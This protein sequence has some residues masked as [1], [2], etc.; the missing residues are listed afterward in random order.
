MSTIYVLG[1]DLGMTS[2]KAAF[3]RQDGSIACQAS[4]RVEPEF[5]QNSWVEINPE[6]WWS[7][8]CSLSKSLLETGGI[9]KSEVKGIAIASAASG[10]TAIDKNRKPLRKSIIWLDNR[11][12][13]DAD[14]LM[15]TFG[16]KDLFFEQTGM[17]LSGRD[18]IVKHIWL[19]QNEPELYA[20][21]RYFLDDA[22]YIL[23]RA[24]GTCVCSRPNAS[25]IAL[26]LE[27]GE[28]DRNLLNAFELDHK[29]YP[30]LVNS[31]ELVGWLTGRAAKD[32]G[33]LAGTSVFGGCTDINGIELGSGCCKP[34]DAFFYLGTSGHVG[35]MSAEVQKPSLAAMPIASTVPDNV[36]MLGTSEV[37]GGCLMWAVENLYKHEFETLGMEALNFADEQLLKTKPGADGLIFANWLCGEGERN[38]MLDECA[39]GGFINLSINHTRDHMLRAIF[40]GCTLQMVWIV[41]EIE[42]LHGIPVPRLRVSGGGALSPNWMQIVAD[43]AGRPVDIVEDASMIV[44][45]GAG[46]LALV[47]LGNM[48]SFEDVSERVKIVKTYLPHPENVVLYRK[49]LVDYITMYLYQKGLYKHLNGGVGGV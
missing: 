29:K 28:W 14:L 31:N 5:P 26:D 19:K 46:Y 23:Y 42:R 9:D 7:V 2:I 38:P 4:G 40:E 12:A 22:G 6:Q 30:P 16:G 11:A 35:T 44:A 34:G 20:N 18:A 43:V 13:A 45:K 24:T 10:V 32:M 49:R 36:T 47:G 3:M 21:T 25:N 1:I 39:R 37:I 27:K 41:N 48:M 8:I 33:L 15:E 17:L